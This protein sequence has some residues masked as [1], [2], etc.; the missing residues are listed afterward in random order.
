MS[1][2]RLCVTVF[3]LSCLLNSF[4]PLLT[5]NKQACFQPSSFI[6]TLRH[7]SANV[8]C[9]CACVFVCAHACVHHIH[10]LKKC[11]F[12]LD[13]NITSYLK[14]TQKHNCQTKRHEIEELGSHCSETIY[15]IPIMSS[16]VNHRL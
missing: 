12:Q 4:S 7:C 13:F 2:S 15:I 8:L 16:K 9:V 14:N 3:K 1:S 5:L 10:I 11:D 6:C